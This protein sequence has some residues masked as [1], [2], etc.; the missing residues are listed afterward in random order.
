MMIMKEKEME[1]ELVNLTLVTDS[2]LKI[3]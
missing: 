3:C 1:S 2:K